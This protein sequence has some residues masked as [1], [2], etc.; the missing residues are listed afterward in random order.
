MVRVASATP[1]PTPFPVMSNF[2]FGYLIRELTPGSGEPVWSVAFTPDGKILASTAGNKVK[3][4][5]VET[6]REL[7]TLT[8]HTDRVWS[9]AF[10]PDGKILAS[11]SSDNTVRL[12][13]PATGGELRTLI[14]HTDVVGSVAFSPDGKSIVSGSNDGTI[15]VWGVR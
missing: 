7:R 10:S 4:W 1:S 5:D 15:R 9:L 11:A 13:D 6:G 14:G 8:G 3:L 12:W 2:L